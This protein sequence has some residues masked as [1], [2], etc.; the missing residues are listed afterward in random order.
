MGKDIKIREEI[1]EKIKEKITNG[2]FPEEIK[3]FLNKM[4]LIE[5]DHIDEIKPRVKEE[6]ESHIKKYA[7][8]WKGE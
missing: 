5:F 3:E 6:Y 4:L 8:K 2:K 7:K 1:N